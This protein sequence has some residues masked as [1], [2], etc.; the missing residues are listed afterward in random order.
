[1]IDFSVGKKNFFLKVNEKAM[2][3][4]KD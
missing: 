1:M 2:Q 4:E 3:K